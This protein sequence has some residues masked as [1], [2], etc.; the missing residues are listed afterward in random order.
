MGLAHLSATGG[1]MDTLPDPMKL[2][3]MQVGFVIVLVTLLYW[4]LRATFFAPV[5]RTI[6]ARDALIQAGMDRRAEAMALMAQQEAEHQARLRELRLRAFEHRRRLAAA[7]AEE[8]QSLLD[9]ARAEAHQTWGEALVR[10][11]AQREAART[12]LL[13]QVDALSESVVQHLLKG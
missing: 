3:L 4:T 6:D 13:A 7:A 1:F 12:N 8:R 10:L 2:D 11:E 9:T 5:L